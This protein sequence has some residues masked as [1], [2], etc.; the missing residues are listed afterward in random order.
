MSVGNLDVTE[1]DDVSHASLC[2]DIIIYLKK[3]SSHW[4]AII[5]I[6]RVTVLYGL[7]CPAFCVQ[8]DLFKI[9]NA[10]F[11]V[12]KTMASFGDLHEHSKATA[13]LEV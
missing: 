5:S 2:M 3:N 12:D 1:S 4:P 7:F 9:D 10:E 6:V 8:S 11:S 13:S